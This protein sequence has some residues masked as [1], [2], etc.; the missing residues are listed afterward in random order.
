MLSNDTA[1][2][3]R[4]GMMASSGQPASAAYQAILRAQEAAGLISIVSMDDDV[5]WIVCHDE[6]FARVLN[7]PYAPKVRS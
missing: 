6:R 4:I 2:P 5:A 3:V 7:L 1:A